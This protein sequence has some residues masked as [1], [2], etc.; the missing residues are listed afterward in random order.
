MTTR[1]CR[2][3][4]LRKTDSLCTHAGH[5]QIE[6]IGRAAVEEQ[7]L[8]D[9]AGQAAKFITEIRYALLPSV[10]DWSDE[11]FEAL[12]GICRSLGKAANYFFSRED[13]RHKSYDGALAEAY[14]HLL[15][16]ECDLELADHF[17]RRAEH[18][19]D[20]LA[21][22]ARRHYF[23]ATDLAEVDRCLD[24]VG[25]DVDMEGGLAR[26]HRGYERLQRD[27]KLAPEVQ[28][29][30]A[31]VLASSEDVESLGLAAETAFELWESGYLSAEPLVRKLAEFRG[32]TDDEDEESSP[33]PMKSK[34]RLSKAVVEDLLKEELQRLQEMIGLASVKTEV[35]GLVALERVRL[36]REEKGIVSTQAPSRHLVLTG[37]PGTGKTTVAR[38]LARIYYLLS[39]SR[40]DTF[41]ETDR[42]DLVGGYLGQTA[43]KTKET[44]ESALGGVLFIDEAYALAAENDSFGAEAINTLLKAMED[45][46]SDLIVIAAGYTADMQKFLE[47]NPG[48]RSRFN[49]IL[50]FED[51]SLDER[52]QIL[53]KMAHADENKFDRSAV[54]QVEA[55]FGAA[56]GSID[57]N[58]N[59]RFVRNFYEKCVKKHAARLIAEHANLKGVPKGILSTITADD[60]FAASQE[61]RIP[62]GKVTRTEASSRLDSLSELLPVEIE[63]T[64]IGPLQ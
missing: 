49:T 8:A 54:H 57:S 58:G 6:K 51:Y 55:T 35:H 56:A 7:E 47:S 16:S 3:D 15:G 14:W 5:K 22:N 43:I 4:F 52:I 32:T 31:K 44:I 41:I 37:N 1:I 60:V 64:R 20:D 19:P 23:S 30:I 38:M 40:T 45:H 34:Q 29:L 13:L 61:L 2:H 26:F 11:C 42:G 25:E 9:W 33:K 46:R 17:L 12:Q 18:S 53:I 63:S 21:E 10:D 27:Q 48:L 50:H 28:R 59:A 24:G 39:I 62:I 36:A